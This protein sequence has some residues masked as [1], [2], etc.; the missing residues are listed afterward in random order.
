MERESQYY[1][2]VAEAEED[3]RRPTLLINNAINDQNIRKGRIVKLYST[4][5]RQISIP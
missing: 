1:A 3:P 4:P 2:V 5:S